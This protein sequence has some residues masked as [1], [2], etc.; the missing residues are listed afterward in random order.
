MLDSA[1]AIIREA[2]QRLSLSEK[3]INNLLS[4]D[5][6]HT[7]KLEVDGKIYDAYRVQ[8]KNIR[9]PYKGGVR[10][11]HEVDFEEVQALAT[12]MSMKTAAVDIPMGGGKGGVVID[13]KGLSNSHLEAV[14]RKY[15]QS[16]HE[17]IGPDK[18]IPAPD[19]NTNAE[20]IDHMVDEYSK[21]TGDETKASFTGKSLDKGGSAGREEATGYGGMMV[22]REV[23]KADGKRPSGMTASVQGIGNVGFYFAQIASMQYG[24]HIVA[25]SN[26]SKTVLKMD[27]FDFSKLKF[28]RSVIDEL[29]KQADHVTDRD[30]VLSEEVDVLACA[31]LADAVTDKN[32]DVVASRYLLELANGPVSHSAYKAL[33]KRGVTVV[34]DIVANAGG[35]IVSYYEWL[36]NKSAERWSAENVNNQLDQTLTSAT[37]KMLLYAKK[38]KLSLKQAAF[39]IAILRLLKQSV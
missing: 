26:S 3:E 6:T 38:N 28:S 2:A 4:P 24:M 19:V 37:D 31:A 16:L 32:Q 17:H 11:H 36:Q 14:A 30:A 10:F 18:D 27:G 7:A 8:H 9:G 39:E 20:I 15:V 5:Q 12:L 35:V 22:L 13:P 33:E 34:P 1:K 21:L 25:V 29:E 23:L